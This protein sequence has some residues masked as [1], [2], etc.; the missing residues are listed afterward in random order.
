MAWHLAARTRQGSPARRPMTE[1]EPMSALAAGFGPGLFVAAQIGP[2]SLL[3][4]RSA[5]RG[6]LRIGLAMAAAV[7]L[8]DLLWCRPAPPARAA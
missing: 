7:T 8:V 5:L 1:S 6:S 4:M 2:V 3:I